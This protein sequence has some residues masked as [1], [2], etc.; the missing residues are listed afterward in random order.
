[1][2]PYRTLPITHQVLDISCRRCGVHG[3]EYIYHPCVKPD[4][5]P[6]CRECCIAWRGISNIKYCIEGAGGF[7]T[8]PPEWKP[9]WCRKEITV[10]G[11]RP[12]I[13]PWLDD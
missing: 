3:H 2:D 11:P 8:Y 6:L 4:S 9:T 5:G 1:M 13:S 7:F 10:P 12:Y